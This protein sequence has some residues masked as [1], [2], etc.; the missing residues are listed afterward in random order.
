M[1]TSGRV[2]LLFV[3]ALSAG[4][5]T[6]D[7]EKLPKLELGMA[8]GSQ[9]LADYRGSDEYNAKA[10][11]V[12]FFVYRGERIKIDR[13]GVRGELLSTPWWEVNVSGEVSLSGGAKDNEARLGMP[14]LDSTFELGPSLNFNL[15]GNSFD[16][17][18]MLRL[19][20]RAVISFSTEGMDYIG[21][22]FNPKFTY[23]R[24]DIYKGWR[25][26]TNIGALYGS[27]DYHD[28][29][30]SVEPRFVQSGRSA[31]NAESGFSGYYLKTSL[32]KRS[33][34]WRY[35]LSVRYDNIGDA[36]FA[37]SPLV[38]SDNYFAVSFLLARYLWASDS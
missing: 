27:D 10:I 9:Y 30:Y 23:I 8:I 14:E 15:S 35:G 19:P 38:K 28:Y 17:G 32:G 29:Y 37:D 31:F 1:S 16:E 6:A 26:S 18:W 34:N 21:S 36:S 5:L 24:E 7:I 25:F 3:G 33:G 13:K 11:P 20:L 22:I 12:P 4:T 2:V